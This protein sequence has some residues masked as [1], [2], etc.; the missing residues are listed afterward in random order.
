MFQKSLCDIF[1]CY[2]IIASSFAVLSTN[3]IVIQISG[4]FHPPPLSV[5]NTRRPPHPSLAITHSSEPDNARQR[6]LITLEC[7]LISR[8]NEY[9]LLSTHGRN[10]NTHTLNT[11]PPPSPL[12]SGHN[13]QKQCFI[14]YKLHYFCSY[15]KTD[16][17]ITMWNIFLFYF[18]VPQRML[19]PYYPTYSR[20]ERS[21]KT[22]NYD[23]GLIGNMTWSKPSFS[24]WRQL[25]LLKK[26]ITNKIQIWYSQLMYRI[27]IEHH[28]INNIKYV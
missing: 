18:G 24:F 5:G 25:S 7:K 9:C 15:K 16:S 28:L 26:I 22:W 8:H 23:R 14:C 13:R 21:V 19:M 11:P 1:N 2:F 20:R 6:H 10:R 3:K 27:K 12:S 17:Q 4:G